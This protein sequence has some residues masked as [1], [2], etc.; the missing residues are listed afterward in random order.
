M[1]MEGKY[2]TEE[3]LRRIIREE[4]ARFLAPSGNE[5]TVD[6][7]EMARILKVDVQTVYRLTR[8]GKISPAKVGRSYRYSPAKIKAQLESPPPPPAPGSWTQSAQSLAAPRGARAERAAERAA[9][10]ERVRVALAAV[11]AYE[12]SKTRGR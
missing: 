3:A 2:V 5:D 4:L 11:D 7:K 8:D 1:D 6:A 12:A 10:S 9:G